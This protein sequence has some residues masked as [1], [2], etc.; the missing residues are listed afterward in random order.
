M[1]IYK[2]EDLEFFTFGKPKAK[3]D[4]DKSESETENGE[5]NSYAADENTQENTDKNTSQVN[6][7]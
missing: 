5:D 4:K 6:N 1:F 7:G 2:D 3:A